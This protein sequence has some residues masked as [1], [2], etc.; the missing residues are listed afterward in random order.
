MFGKLDQGIINIAKLLND[1]GFLTD[2]QEIPKSIVGTYDYVTGDLKQCFKCVNHTNSERAD[3]II[4]LIDNEWDMWVKANPDIKTYKKFIANYQFFK[5]CGSSQVSCQKIVEYLKEKF[6]S[7]P[8][9][10]GRKH[11][12]KKNKKK[13]K[14]KTIKRKKGKKKSK[15][16]GKKKTVKRR[17]K[18]SRK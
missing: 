10:G 2:T 17:S 5:E 7:L 4:E 18:K 11:K 9:E 14:K 1:K 8:N 6:E 13:G 15:K 16:R 12:T 3:L